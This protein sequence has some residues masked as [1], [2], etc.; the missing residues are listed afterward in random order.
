MHGAGYVADKAG[1]FRFAIL[2]TAFNER[3]CNYRGDLMKDLQIDNNGDLIIAGHDFRL[4]S[5]TSLTRQKVGLVLGTN[6]GEWK[7]GSGDGINFKAILGKNPS[8][9]EI[10]DTVRDGLRQ[11]D[12]SFV[13]TSYDFEQKQR[14]MILKFKA[15]NDSGEEVSLAVGSNPMTSTA[16]K[17]KTLLVCSMDAEKVLISGSALTAM[18]ICA[19]DGEV[20]DCEL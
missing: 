12:E 11:I 5:G 6:K 3:L 15:V 2:E 8:R 4:V 14:H 1:N 9:E 13:I 18:S 17:Q 7:L 20:L 10:L 19:S 16:G